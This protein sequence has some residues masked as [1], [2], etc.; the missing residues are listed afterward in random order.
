[1]VDFE[2][3]KDEEK[4]KRAII[5]QLGKGSHPSTKSSMDCIKWILDETYKKG[6]I[7][8]DLSEMRQDIFTFASQSTNQAD[9]CMSIVPKLHLRSKDIE[10]GEYPSGEDSDE[11]PIAFY[12]VEVFPNLFV[13]CWKIIGEGHPVM[14]LINPDGDEIKELCKLYRLVGFNCR[15]YDNHIMYARMQ[16]YS[17]SQL[18]KISTDI[19]SDDKRKQK[20]CFFGGA[21]NLSY[22][23]IWDYASNKQGLKK[24]EI[25]LGIHHQELGLPWDKPVPEELWQK[26]ADYCVNDVIATEAV[27][28]ATQED[29]KARE[30]LADLAGGTVNMTTNTLVQKII[31]GDEKHPTLVYTNL[32]TGEQ[33]E[34]R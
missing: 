12:D 33:S 34:G 4:L 25:Q 22:T 3:F 7:S 29:F 21:Y 19:V 28:N 15:R 32:A 14:K 1:M 17:L 27:W 16:G 20:S 10:E 31:F 2:G 24:W 18:Y 5:K 13:V 26:V 6:E 11:K 30:I 23:D 9:Y 8:Y